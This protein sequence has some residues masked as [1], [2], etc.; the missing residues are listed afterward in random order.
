PRLPETVQTRPAEIVG[1]RAVGGGDDHD[2][3][4]RPTRELNETL[5][6]ARAGQVPAPG[7]DEVPTRRSD[8]GLQ[9]RPRRRRRYRRARGYR[10]RQDHTE[11][12]ASRAVHEPSR[13]AGHSLQEL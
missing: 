6:D 13:A 11:E 5:E 7:D 8:S 3:R 2:A 1:S 9:R 4:V 10:S 12:A